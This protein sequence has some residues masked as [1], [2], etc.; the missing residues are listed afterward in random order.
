MEEIL[1]VM[2]AWPE[3]ELNERI[4]RQILSEGLAA[5]VQILPAMRSFFPWE[6]RME[7]ASEHLMLCKTLASRYTS[8]EQRL[9]DLHPYEVPEILAVPV[10]YVHEAYGLWL[11][12]VLEEGGPSLAN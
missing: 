3:Q 4:V 7:S 2:C 9:R 8:L 12:Q 10:R 11:A 1:L 6:G 5:C